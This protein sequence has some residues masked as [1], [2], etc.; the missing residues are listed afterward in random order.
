MIKKKHKIKE[1]RGNTFT[2]KR[3]KGKKIKKI[4]CLPL[5]FFSIIFFFSSQTTVQQVHEPPQSF[6]LLF[7][8]T[9]DGISI[10]TSSNLHGRTIRFLFFSFLSFQK[11]LY[12]FN[13]KYAKI[14]TIVVSII[15]WCSEKKYNNLQTSR[16]IFF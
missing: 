6:S 3:R 15:P 12:P 2:V 5:S 11:Q 9:M 4:R 8:P 13:R 16:L 14:S 7:L 10:V 1:D